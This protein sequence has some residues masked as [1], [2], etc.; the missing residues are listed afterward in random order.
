M[1]NNITPENETR[2]QTLARE[3]AFIESIPRVSDPVLVRILEAWSSQEIESPR[4]LAEMTL[5]ERAEW[6]IDHPEVH[7]HQMTRFEAMSVLSTALKKG[8]LTDGQFHE[9]L[10]EGK[11]HAGRL[12]ILQRAYR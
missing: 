10:E 2:E 5:L 9:L 3:R 1:F 11:T 8:Q 7:V 6:E 4:P 12:A